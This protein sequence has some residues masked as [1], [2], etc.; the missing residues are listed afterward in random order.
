MP[1]IA[2]SLDEVHYDHDLCV[3]VPL[4]LHHRAHLLCL[5]PGADDAAAPPAGEEDSVR[6]GQVGALQ[7]CLRGALLLPHPD[8]AAGGGR[9]SAL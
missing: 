7:E 1:S 5:L 4:Q 3:G 6:S 9:R 2:S 8:G